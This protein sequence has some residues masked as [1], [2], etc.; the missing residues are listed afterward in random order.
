MNNENT[1]NDKKAWKKTILIC[2]LIEGLMIITWVVYKF[3][4]APPS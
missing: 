2:A 1:E 4:N 3:L